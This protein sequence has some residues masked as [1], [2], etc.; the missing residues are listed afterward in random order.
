MRIK[1]SIYASLI[2]PYYKALSDKD[3]SDS[4]LFE[5]ILLVYI[6]CG[7]AVMCDKYLIPAIEKIKERY[8]ISERL[9]GSTILALGSSISFIASNM[10]AVLSNNRQEFELGLTCILGASIFELTIG[11]AIGCLLIRKQYSICFNTLTKDLLI[12]F[13]TLVIL[14]CYIQAET[15]DFTKV[16]CCYIK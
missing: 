1:S 11:L 7:F 3:P 15:I 10:N 2:N 4:I 8:G 9:A 13:A 6:F 12:Y 16:C 14:F 5:I